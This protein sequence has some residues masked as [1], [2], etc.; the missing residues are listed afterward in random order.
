[1][2]ELQGGIE[3]REIEVLDQSALKKK[4][5]KSREQKSPQNKTNP[6]SYL[7]SIILTQ[8]FLCVGVSDFS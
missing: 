2:T 1:M 7:N 4:K 8:D 5:E 3:W 6:L